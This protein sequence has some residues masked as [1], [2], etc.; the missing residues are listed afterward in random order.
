VPR[1]SKSINSGSDE[2][3]TGSVRW[4]FSE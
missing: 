4:D 3:G 2:G 1:L